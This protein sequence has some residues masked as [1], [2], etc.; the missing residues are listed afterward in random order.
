[1]GEMQYSGN[2]GEINIEGGTINGIITG[3]IATEG[4][5]LGIETSLGPA[6]AL[7]N[8]TVADSIL[9]HVVQGDLRLLKGTRIESSGVFVSVENGRIEL[10]GS[11][12]VDSFVFLAQ[13]KGDVLIGKKSEIGSGVVLINSN[14]TI[15]DSGESHYMGPLIELNAIK[16][17]FLGPATQVTGTG[18]S[19][20]LGVLLFSPA[21]PVVTGPGNTITSAGPLTLEAPVVVVDSPNLLRPP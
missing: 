3:R 5:F 9:L 18:V 12:V 16:G 10:A 21:G 20:F 2:S 11:N 15:V 14:G 4:A 17:V 1:Q 13:A 7:G 6:A 8:L 19:R